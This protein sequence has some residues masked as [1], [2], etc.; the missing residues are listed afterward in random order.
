TATASQ[1]VA[2]QGSSA[3]SLAASNVKVVPMSETSSG[4]AVASAPV[5]STPASNGAENLVV[6][7]QNRTWMSVTDAQGKVLISEVVPAGAVKQFSGSAPYKVVLGY[8]LGARIQF[9]GQD[10]AI[11]QSK[12]TT[13]SLTV[14]G[15]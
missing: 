11:P 10:V 8:A 15:N 5:T 2:A 7:V 6:T 3:A 13:A 14:G 4:S 1:E 12:K 9:A